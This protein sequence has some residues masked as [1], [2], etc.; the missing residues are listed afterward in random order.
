MKSIA[1]TSERLANK[2]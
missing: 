1:R 2:S